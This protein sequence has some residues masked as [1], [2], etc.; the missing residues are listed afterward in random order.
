VHRQNEVARAA[1]AERDAFA[2][3][4]WFENS[5]LLRGGS[6]PL[7]F[8]RSQAC[9]PTGGSAKTTFAAKISLDF[10]ETMA[11]SQLV[12]FLGTAIV[13]AASI[14]QTQHLVKEHCSA[15]ISMNAYGP[16]CVT[17]LL[18]LIQAAMIRDSVFVFVQI[19]NLIAIVAIVICVQ[20]Y[21]RNMSLTHLYEAHTKQR[22][23]LRKEGKRG[24]K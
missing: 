22:S 12:E 10:E 23:S 19:V 14:P 17:P 4:E 16:W 2:N 13:A 15:G 20:K 24:G 8:L 11:F 18:F 21:E 9:L 3:C 6:P 5:G 7:W 1:D